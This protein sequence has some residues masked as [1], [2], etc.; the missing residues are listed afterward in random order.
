MKVQKNQR[1]LNRQQGGFTL[2]E[3]MIA[4]VLGLV[5]LAGVGQLFL[6][7]SSTFRTQRQVADIQDSGRF[8]MWLL[9]SDI[10]RAGWIEG[11][12]VADGPGSIVFV[13]DAEGG[14]DASDILTVVYEGTTDCNGNETATAPVVR[15]QYSIDDENQLMCLGSGSATPQP[16]LSNVD[17]FQ[18]LY[19]VDVPN[20]PEATAADVCSDRAA[21][22]Y[23]T[24]D[25]IPA[26]SVVVSVRFAMLIGSEP[27][28]SI[29]TDE[30]D[31]NVAD[32]S[33]T[34][35]D[36]ILRRVFTLTVPVSNLPAIQ[37]PCPKNS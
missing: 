16:L 21:D 8:A 7:S 33:V 26:D 34:L 3:V 20:P 1:S 36:N 32:Q 13:E 28:A 24:A 17:S 11:N 27:N 22:Q 10:E 18:V 6:G 35:N 30:R 4:G 15:N 2:V 29:P 19:G 5:L 23:V 14:D 37:G 25:N 31:Y 12:S 9:K